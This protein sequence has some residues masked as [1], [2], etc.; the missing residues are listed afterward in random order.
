[1]LYFFFLDIVLK[2]NSM[3][4]NIVDF[5]VEQIVLLLLEMFVHVKIPAFIDFS[6]ELKSFLSSD[7]RRL[8]NQHPATKL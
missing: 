1:M 6:I 8:L 7:F 2:N 3:N 5:G 4:Y